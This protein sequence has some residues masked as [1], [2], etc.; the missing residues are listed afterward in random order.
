[1][2]APLVFFLLIRIQGWFCHNMEGLMASRLLH[3]VNRPSNRC[4]TWANFMHDKL[5]VC[6]R[7]AKPKFEAQN[8]PALYYLQQVDHARGKTRNISQVE[9]FCIEDIVTTFKAAI[10]KIQFF[11]SH[12]SQPLEHNA[13]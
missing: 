2:V 12:I 1:M 4:K 3:E 7:A 11:V 10:Y 6:E 9:S 8:R 13:T 5:P